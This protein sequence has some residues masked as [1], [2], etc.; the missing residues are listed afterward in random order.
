MDYRPDT[1][2]K[3]TITIKN[4]EDT[5]RFGLELAE[6]C[7]PGTVIA[8][9]GN[10]GTGKTTLTKYIAEGLGIEGPITSPTFT[11]VQEHRDGRLPLFHFDVYRITDP[12][13]MFEI[14][15]DEYFYGK[16]VSI[17]DWAEQIMEVMPEETLFVLIEYGEEESER[18]YKCT[19]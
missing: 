6:K 13:D 9:I 1:E 17:V 18:V 8:L 11:I 19:F 14:G 2:I 4:E 10:L 7:T 12:E 3:R 5:R 16:G 15:A